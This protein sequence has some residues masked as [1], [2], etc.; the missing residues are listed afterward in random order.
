MR[1]QSQPRKVLEKGVDGDM[2]RG[3]RVIVLHL[4][5]L[6]LITLELALMTK[7]KADLGQIRS[8]SL[9]SVHPSDDRIIVRAFR[10]LP[11][12]SN[13]S[14]RDDFRLTCMNRAQRRDT[15]RACSGLKHSSVYGDWM[16]EHSK[17]HGW[18]A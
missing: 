9:I 17:H 15:G 13:T 14:L 16:R 6:Q 11:A 5:V 3:K 10:Y 7:Q 4:G 2:C 8:W 12:Q 1:R 18:T